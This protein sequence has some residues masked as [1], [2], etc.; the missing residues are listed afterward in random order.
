MYHAPGSRI[1]GAMIQRAVMVKRTTKQKIMLFDGVCNFCSGGVLFSVKRLKDADV[2]FCPMQSPAGQR[3]L[4]RLGF[5]TTDYQ[6][7]IYV[8]NGQTFTKSRAAVRLSRSL[9]APWPFWGRVLDAF[10]T[11]LADRFYDLSA[12]HRYKKKEKKD[13]CM[14]PDEDVRERFIL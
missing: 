5:P 13:A 14:A 6:T 9:K 1:R 4:K 2:K 11:P 8:E 7:F 3:M 12:R 10:P